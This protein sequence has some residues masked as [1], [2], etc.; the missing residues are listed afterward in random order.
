MND[1]K[2]T[3]IILGIGLTAFLL[4]STFLSFP[5]IFF[6]GAILIALY[7][8]VFVYV[9][10]FTSSFIIDSLRVVNFGYT[11]I[12]L[13]STILLIFL[14]EKYSG[15]RDAIVA[16]IFIGM[17]GFIYTHIMSYS[18][19]L[20]VIFYILIIVGYI[21]LKFISNKKILYI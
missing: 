12:F 6:S 7:K 9:M 4:E 5:I 2:L 1:V 15:S 13:L 3:L 8:K 11:S 18:I 19:L 21:V 17:V 16:T 20:T 10:V 14:Y